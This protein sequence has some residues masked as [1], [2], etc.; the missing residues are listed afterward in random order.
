MKLEQLN[1]TNHDAI[2]KEMRA[3]S[4]Q[5]QKKLFED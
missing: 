4:Q 1:K 3:L 5:N 2:G